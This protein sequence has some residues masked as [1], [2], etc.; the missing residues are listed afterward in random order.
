[1]TRVDAGDDLCEDGCVSV[2]AFTDAAGVELD[3]EDARS[4]T[5]GE[6]FKGRDGCAGG[7]LDGGAG[8]FAFSICRN[9]ASIAAILSS[10]LFIQPQQARRE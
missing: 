1:M 7:N 10:V 2:L 4:E 5:D 6:G 9:F 8:S 3:D